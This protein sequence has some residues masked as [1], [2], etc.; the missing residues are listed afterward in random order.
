MET[1]LVGAHHR[2]GADRQP[3]DGDGED[4]HRHQNLYQGKTVSRV[5]WSFRARFSRKHKAALSPSQTQGIVTRPT[6]A[7]CT[8]FV[9]LFPFR[10]VIVLA[11]LAVPRG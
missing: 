4:G 6:T 9:S 10:T 3:Q 5:V 2:G 7:T 11:A 1:G 8:D